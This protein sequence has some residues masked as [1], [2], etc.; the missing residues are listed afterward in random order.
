[1][2]ARATEW[3]KLRG[4][5]VAG[6]TGLALTGPEVLWRMAVGIGALDVIV[7][8]LVAR[9]LRAVKGAPDEL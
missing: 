3:G 9:P 1:M 5:R 7:G 8:E 6:R 2:A 4:L